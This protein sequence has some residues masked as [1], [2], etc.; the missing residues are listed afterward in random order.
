MHS[1]I[2]VWRAFKAD[3]PIASRIPCYRHWAF[4]VYARAY[5]EN[6]HFVNWA[7]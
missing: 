5:F 4:G 6:R 7:N 2:N 3:A 1:E